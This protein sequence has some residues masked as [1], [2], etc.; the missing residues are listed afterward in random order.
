MCGISGLGLGTGTSGSCHGIQN[1]GKSLGI[2]APKKMEYK[3]K[4][5]QWLSYF[6][7]AIVELLFLVR[8]VGNTNST[9]FLALL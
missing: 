1:N 9:C 6:S 4:L 8:N 7:S 3:S 2:G 5:L